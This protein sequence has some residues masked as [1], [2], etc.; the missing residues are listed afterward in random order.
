MLDSPSTNRNL[1]NRA[2]TIVLAPISGP[3][4]G[5]TSIDWAPMSKLLSEIESS[6]RNGVFNKK[7]DYA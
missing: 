3:E 7:Q 6:L 1:P 4:I 5:T 2:Q